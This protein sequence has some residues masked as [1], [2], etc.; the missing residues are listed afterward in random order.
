[1]PDTPDIAFIAALVGD[2]TRGRMLSSLMD[3]EAHTATELALEGGVTPATASSH[4]ARLTDAG[5]VTVARRGRH[6]YFRVASAEVASAIEGLMTI[7]PPRA[8]RLAHVESQREP[9]RLARVCY[10]HLAGEAGVRMMDR[11]RAARF[12]SGSDAA[13]VLTARGAQWCDDLGIDVAALR[14]TRR[15]LCRACL[16]WTERRSHLAGALGAAILARLFA[17]RWARREPGS[18]VVTLTRRGDFFI[19]QLNLPR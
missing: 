19:E 9:V 10:D 8:P 5:L 2:P 3:G 18:R 17:L 6:R 12:I 16:D 11:M 14:A 7:A 15:R 4:L 1:M 13:L